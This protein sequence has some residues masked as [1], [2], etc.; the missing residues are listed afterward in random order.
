LIAR[1][2]EEIGNNVLILR[3][4]KN[5]EV[6]FEKLNKIAKI[7]ILKRK[8]KYSLIKMYLAHRQCSH[9][10]IIHIHLR[11]VFFY[12]YLVRFIFRGKYKL[13]LHDHEGNIELTKDKPPIKFY[14]LVKPDFYLCV[15]N[16]LLKWANEV[17]QLKQEK[18]FIFSNL[19]NEEFRVLPLNSSN[20]RDVVS[21]GNIKPIKNQL[22]ALELSNANNFNLTFYGNIQDEDYYRELKSEIESIKIIQGLK[23]DQDI[24]RKHSM[25]ISTSI[26][27]SGPMV[28]IEYLLSG[29][30]FLAYKTGDIAD[31]IYEL[32]PEFFLEDFDVIN[33]QFAYQNLLNLDWDQ[34][35]FEVRR[36]ELLNRYF[37]V[38][39]YLINLKEVY[40]RV[41]YE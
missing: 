21:V 5:D 15:S 40:N 13:I 11:H 20:F 9:Y 8:N 18:T 23:I 17:W 34:S 41:M 16:S 7:F 29:L 30:P 12:F 31:K 19:Y 6:N 28:L 39:N 24:L 2:R 4:E 3:R 25:G 10:S 35:N 37:D 27:E 38:D 1:F 14:K 22:F 32:F 26:S 36:Q 33:W